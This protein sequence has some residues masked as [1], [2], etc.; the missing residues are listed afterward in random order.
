MPFELAEYGHPNA[1]DAKIPRKT[2][3][4]SQEN[5]TEFFRVLRVVF[6]SFAFGCPLFVT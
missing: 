4:E 5:R 1:K 3:K 2:Q 6:A